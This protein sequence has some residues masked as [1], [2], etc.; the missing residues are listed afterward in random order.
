MYLYIHGLLQLSEV[1]KEISLCNV[2]WLTQKLPPGQSVKS[3]CLWNAQSQ[4]EHLSISHFF[5]LRLRNHC[6]RRGRKHVRA[7][8]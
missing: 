6:R 4:M 3:K 1:I 5:T 7:R 8:G 2:W